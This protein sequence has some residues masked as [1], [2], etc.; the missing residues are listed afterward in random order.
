VI[1]DSSALLSAVL[2]EPDAALYARPIAVS[3]SRR[4]PSVTWFEA[5][6]RIDAKGDAFAVGGFD[7]FPREFQTDTLPSTS[8]HAREARRARMR[9]GKPHHPARL[10]FGDFSVYGVAKHE[11]ETPL[12]K[13]DDVSRTDIEPALKD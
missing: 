11:R 9:H 8:D 4:I 6:A 10:N 2:A 1:V 7:D 3:D 13:G 5:A 12:F